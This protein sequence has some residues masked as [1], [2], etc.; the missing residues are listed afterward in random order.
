MFEIVS[1]EFL[2]DYFCPIN[3]HHTLSPQHRV[4]LSKQHR[5]LPFTPPN[6][7]I[8]FS[9]NL[10]FPLG[11]F[12]STN[13]CNKY[14]LKRILLFPF[15]LMSH[16]LYTTLIHTLNNLYISIRIIESWKRA[17]CCRI[18]AKEFWVFAQLIVNRV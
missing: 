1:Y 13:S 18:T 8:N 6:L 16:Y 14:T 15:H 3:I 17:D 10:I 11:L 5:L 4:Q 9:F 12:F 7:F 2:S